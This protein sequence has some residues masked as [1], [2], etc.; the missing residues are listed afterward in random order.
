MKSNILTIMNLDIEKNKA[1]FI[2][3]LKSTNREGVDDM[4]EELCRLDFFNAPASA[5]HHLNVEGGLALHSLYT[6]K[7]ALAI[8]EAM[9]P[10]EPSLENEVTRDSVIIASLLHDVCKSDIYVRTVKKRKNAIGQWED[11]E[12]YKTSYKNFPMGHGEKS[13][14]L[15]L[16]GGLELTDA[17]M[18]AIRW[19]MGAWGINMNSIE[20][21]KNF[22]IAQK[23]HPLVCI[24][25]TADNL[26]ANI[27]ERTG[28][29]LD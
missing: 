24:I 3:L 16:C 13:V 23:L 10:I 1:E 26:A 17:E 20:E 21:V 27:L 6:C 28:E 2:H 8:W 14:I 5:G 11:C 12:G 25:H 19:H 7:A 4:I 22:D 15:I 9:K 29:E 18:L